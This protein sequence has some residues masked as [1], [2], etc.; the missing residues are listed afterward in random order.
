VS[1]DRLILNLE[2]ARQIV[3]RDVRSEQ[4]ATIVA[5]TFSLFVVTIVFACLLAGL[6]F[7][8]A[9]GFIHSVRQLPHG[10]RAGVLIVAIV[11][12]SAGFLG[13][14]ILVASALYDS[15]LP[16]DSRFPLLHETA[17]WL[18]LLLYAPFGIVF[19][20]LVVGPWIVLQSRFAYQGRFKLARALD[21][22]GHYLIRLS[23]PYYKNM[24][25][26]HCSEIQFHA[27]NYEVARDM[28]GKAFDSV[29]AEYDKDNSENNLLSFIVV[30][31]SYAA[32]EGM[33][34]LKN[35]ATPL[36][37]SLICKRDEIERMPVQRQ[38][39]AFSYLAYG[40][41]HLGQTE[42]ALLFSELA[43]AA[44][45]KTKRNIPPLAGCIAEHWAL[46]ALDKGMLDRA[47]EQ[48]LSM[49]KH[50]AAVTSKTAERQADSY[51]VLGQVAL[52]KGQT[53]LAS[54]Q[55]SLAIA[56]RQIRNGMHHPEL[57]KYESHC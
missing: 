15:L 33:S 2:K 10:L 54:E 52:A 16:Y 40:C 24:V 50:W 23:P 8:G 22:V 14:L 31:S 3:L 55:L 47:H 38:A 51:Y 4:L 39:E 11:M 12:L 46:A 56:I 7:H 6:C 44:Y 32:L 29:M 1:T 48:A 25:A 42:R 19:P 18:H 26:A 30:G 43:A 37:E 41:V 49:Q 27:G 36:M 34:G 13:T 57:L 53:K 21:G 45:E 5:V 35:E 28:A 20:S 17:R 9:D